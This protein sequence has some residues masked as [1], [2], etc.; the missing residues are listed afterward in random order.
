MKLFKTTYYVQ[1]FL[2]NKLTNLTHVAYSSKFKNA[3]FQLDGNKNANNSFFF[4]LLFVQNIDV[5]LSDHF[6]IVHKI[7]NDRKKWKKKVDQ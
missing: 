7:I 5:R 2:Y 3:I 4:I 1:H 6:S